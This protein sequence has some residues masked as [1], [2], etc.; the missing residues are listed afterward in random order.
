MA[1]TNSI[2]YI[3]FT[4][5]TQRLPH[6]VAKL[7]VKNEAL[8]S[9]KS[10]ARSWENPLT[11][12]ASISLSA[13]TLAL[14]KMS[15]YIILGTPGAFDFAAFSE[16]TRR[17]IAMLAPLAQLPDRDR[18]SLARSISQQAQKYIKTIQLGLQA[19]QHGFTATE[20]ILALADLMD[21]STSEDRE[22]YLIGTLELADKAYT[23]AREAFEGFRNIRS[24]IYVLTAQCHEMLEN[25]ATIYWT[26]SQSEATMRS[27][28]ELPQAADVL[29]S[30]AEQASALARWWDWVRI[31][32]QPRPA[33]SAIVFDCDSLL[34]PSV[35]ERWR[36]LRF[37]FADYTNMVRQLEDRYPGLLGRSCSMERNESQRR[38]PRHPSSRG[39][40]QYRRDLRRAL[41][42]IHTHDQSGP[43]AM[44]SNFS[45]TSYSAG[46][47]D[48]PIGLGLPSLCCGH[49][50][51]LKA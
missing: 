43:G 25:R 50:K 37:Q 16:S 45:P 23:S 21:R 48:E 33:K 19:A 27:I 24:S 29:E 32:V 41:L 36:L 49:A 51:S 34:L 31:E 12:A 8:H 35:V 28:G 10:G 14:S 22:R 47:D 13:T 38:V 46:R 17:L 3:S 30:F 4:C 42:F 20:D 1:M 15:I 40:I 2:P 26:R 6:R 5:E 44:R 9:H 11:Y 18:S 7:L 39:A